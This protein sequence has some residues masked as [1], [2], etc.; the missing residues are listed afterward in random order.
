M[1]GW[2]RSGLFDWQDRHLC[3]RTNEVSL[4]PQSASDYLVVSAKHKMLGEDWNRH[5]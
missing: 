3:N 4:T 5:L 1:T 2:G